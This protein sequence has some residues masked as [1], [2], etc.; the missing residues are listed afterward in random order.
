MP[1]IYEVAKEII[2]RKPKILGLS[3]QSCSHAFNEELAKVIKKE[4]PSIIIVVGNI[5]PG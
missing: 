2:K 1:I 3:V 5:Y 4:M